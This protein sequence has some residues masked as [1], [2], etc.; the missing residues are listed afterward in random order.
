ME[1]EKNE[2]M[3]FKRIAKDAIRDLFGLAVAEIPRKGV[4]DPIPPGHDDIGAM[5]ADCC[6]ERLQ[7]GGKLEV[8]IVLLIGIA[9]LRALEEVREGNRIHELAAVLDRCRT[10][11]S[12]IDESREGFLPVAWAFIREVVV[13]DIPREDGAFGMR[14]RI[15]AVTAPVPTVVRR[16][17]HHDA[18]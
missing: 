5:F 9:A 6:L 8:F 7:V 13:D 15:A 16:S 4:P 3:A 11:K 1:A 12:R 2:G 17:K 14:R 18:L 10:A